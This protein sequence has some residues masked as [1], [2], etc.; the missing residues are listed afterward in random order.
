MKTKQERRLEI[1]KWE[2]ENRTSQ[3]RAIKDSSCLYSGEIGCGVGRL[4]E[5]KDLC[6]RLD[7]FDGEAGVGNHSVFEQLPENVK[8]LGQGFLMD[9]QKLHDFG[10]YWTPNGLSD[11][12]NDFMAELKMKS[13]KKYF[14]NFDLDTWD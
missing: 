2:K 1:L 9:L 10:H 7:S 11:D 6:A 4:I 14:K 5:D 12:G 13:M 8:E 3:N